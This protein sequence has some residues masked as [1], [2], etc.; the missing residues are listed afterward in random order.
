MPARLLIVALDA[1]DARSLDQ[2]SLDGRLPNLAALRARGIA[3]PLSTPSGA[4]DDGLWASFQYGVG[5]G[6][7]GRYSYMIQDDRGGSR[8]ADEV[9][10]DRLTFWD[11]LS[12][13]GRRVAIIDVPKCRRP[14][15]LGGIHL[16]DWLVHGR[17]FPTPLSYPQALA[18]EVVQR[19]GA[20]PPSACD[21]EIDLPSDDHVRAARDNLLNSVRQKRAAGVHFLSTDAWDLFAIGFKEAH[22]AGHMFW[23]LADP[24]HA[25]HDPVRAAKLGNP[26]MDVLK[27]QD[28]ALGEIV[29]AAG[30]GTDILLF[31]TS[32]FAPNGSITHLVPEILERVNRH[33][34]VP[35]VDRVRFAL[36][37]LRGK[38]ALAPGCRNLLYNDNAV[39]L[40]LPCRR[41][42]SAAD[43]ARRLDQI[44]ALISELLDVDDGLPVITDVS[45][46]SAENAGRRAEGLPHLLFHVRDNICSRAVMS[47]RLGRIAA[48]RPKHPRAGNHVAGAIAFAAGPSAGLLAEQIRSLEDFAAAAGHLLNADA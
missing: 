10:D 30:P 28:A 11:R 37:Q 7:H 29:E 4:T 40:R 36:A 25:R 9:E 22:C 39:A 13:Q 27:E 24:G 47:K 44:A 16:A 5:L 3:W 6:E 26:L 33:C 34:G 19:F 21:Y 1:A 48:P 14:I 31:S 8:Q 17:Y 42:E 15:P 2:A 38:Q 46:P 23:D 12:R 20:A 43:H 41:R 32:C 18:A 35:L 45:R